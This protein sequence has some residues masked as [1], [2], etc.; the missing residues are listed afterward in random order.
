[1][2]FI[3]SVSVN[4]DE[5]QYDIMQ[6]G[7]HDSNYAFHTYKI[8]NQGLILGQQ[9]D[10]LEHRSPFYSF[11]AKANGND[12]EWDPF[13]LHYNFA[14]L[15]N[16]GH[17]VGSSLSDGVYIKDEINQNMTYPDITLHGS[18]IGAADINDLGQ[19][20]GHGVLVNNS[21]QHAYF[22]FSINNTWHTIDLG[23]LGG[24]NSYAKAINNAGIVVGHSEIVEASTTNNAFVASTS[25]NGWNM[26]NLGTLGGAN[27]YAVDINNSNQVVG[28]SDHSDGMQHA[29]LASQNNIGA[30]VMTDLGLAREDNIYQ[31]NTIQINDSGFIVWN[32]LDTAYLYVNGQKYKLMDLIPN[33]ANWESVAKVTSISNAG[34]IIGSGKSTPSGDCCAAY[35]LTPVVETTNL[36]PICETGVDPKVIR[37]GE[38]TALWWWSQNASTGTINNQIG[39]ISVPSDYKWIHPTETTTYTMTAKGA[40][41]TA[42]TCQATVVVE[43]SSVPNPPICEIG[44]DPQV[45]SAGEGTALWWWTQN[46]RSANIDNNIGNVE[47]PSQYKW[48]HPSATTTYKMK[49]L[50][51]NGETTICQTTITV[52]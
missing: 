50:G 46:G 14:S 41:G 48:I 29:F 28:F 39:N 36:P 21:Q 43:G 11:L 13:R 30:I 47:L 49:A 42:T 9:K 51:V 10:P 18:S 35:V 22:A 6:I 20:V 16:L 24:G 33:H 15:N 1:M 4:A 5:L 37:A 23:T 31:N 52:E 34:Q 8:N 26:I 12:I 25:V 38:G 7:I 3:S 32:D 44:L 45:I 27:S 17:L 19:I 40:N 2:V